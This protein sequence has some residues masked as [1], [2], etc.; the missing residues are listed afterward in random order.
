MKKLVEGEDYI[1][2]KS[3]EF[4]EYII[5]GPW[6]M[7]D[8]FKEAL[9]KE[10]EKLLGYSITFPELTKEQKQFRDKWNKES[11][12]EWGRLKKYHGY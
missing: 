11:K 1:V 3:P 2:V 5:M 10:L 6:K 8:A 4:G 7:S 12:E 9:H